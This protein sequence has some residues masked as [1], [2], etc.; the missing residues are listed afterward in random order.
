MH[1]REPEPDGPDPREP[2]PVREP[3]AEEDDPGH[4]P[5]EQPEPLPV[6]AL[7]DLRPYADPR[8][9]VDVARRGIRASRRPA[10]S[11]AR[12]AAAGTA[13]TA[14]HTLAGT[15][16]LLGLLVGWLTGEYGKH[17]SR[18]MRLGG[19]VVVLLGIV[20]TFAEYPIEGAVAAAGA[21][22]LAA[23][24]TS[25]GALDTLL[26]KA[27]GE[28][29][30]DS[31]KTTAEPAGDAPPPR[32]KR[33][34]GRRGKK[35]A[36]TAGEQPEQAPAEA[37]AEPP[38]TALIRELIGD[39]NGVHLAVLR[40]AMRERLPGLAQAT[41]QQLRKVLVDAGFDPSRT[42]RARGVAGRAGI[43]RDELPPPPSPDTGPGAERISSPPPKSGSDLGI[44]SPALR[45]SPRVKSRGERLRQLPEGWTAED[46][47]RGY[48]WVNDAARGPS[49]WVMER[50]EDVE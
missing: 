16:T 13:F 25:R 43:H 44:S 3:D 37:P 21:W 38:L 7:P 30:K 32:W 41:D 17:G 22:C 35:P 46:I 36:P 23:I 48:R 47:A 45:R 10:R 1:E 50:L 24:A 8:A 39:D 27:T 15:R 18:L 9:V 2:E 29:Q 19:V 12:R 42:F 4:E 6:L 5:G 14:R 26:K 40:P 28:Q 20:H 11:L 34:T 33:L 49:A 31:R